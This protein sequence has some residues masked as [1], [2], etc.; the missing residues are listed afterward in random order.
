MILF[1]FIVFA[2]FGAVVSNQLLA[3]CTM[4]QFMAIIVING[5]VVL[6]LETWVT[7]TGS[8]IF[9]D[10]IRMM[11]RSFQGFIATTAYLW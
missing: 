10:H 5:I 1:A 3:T 6:F 11:I 7:Y 2:N 4:S 9:I 8:P